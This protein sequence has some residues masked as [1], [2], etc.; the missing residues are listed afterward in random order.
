MGFQPQDRLALVRSWATA[1][2]L[3]KREPFSSAEVSAVRSWASERL[4]DTPYLPGI[5]PG[6]GN[7]FN[8]LKRDD[9]ALGTASILAGGESRARFLEQYAFDLRPATDDRPYFFHFFRWR[10]LPVLLSALGA[11][12]IPFV[13]W[14]CLVLIATF[15]QALV[16]SVLLIPAPLAWAQRQTREAYPKRSL[17]R[18]RLQ[19]LFYFLLLGVGYLFVEMAMIQR[20]VFLLAN[21]IYA[22][23]VALTGLLLLSGLGSGWAAY[24]IAQGSSAGRLASVAALT[25]AVAAAAYALGLRT[26]FELLLAWPLL[27][28]TGVAVAVMMPLIAMGIPFPLGLRELRRGGR[29]LLPWAWAVNGCASVVA[30][31]LA[32]LIALSAGFATVLLVAATCYCGT[33]LLARRW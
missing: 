10:A 3:V 28:R 14:G 19:T 21:P 4:F 33:A 23:A 15:V 8:V 2:L 17:G 7:R 32:T 26:V 18:G 27:A 20:L 29:D 16:V 31:S 22:V 5:A 1:T 9:Y 13:E 30:A 6:E 12:W 25:V 11:A 24:R